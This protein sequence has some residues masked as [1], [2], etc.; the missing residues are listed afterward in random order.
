MPSKTCKL[1]IPYAHIHPHIIRDAGFWT[2]RWLHAGRSPS[3]LAR[4]TRRLWFPTGLSNLNSSDHRTLFHF[5]KQSILNEPWPTGHNGASGPW[6]LMASFLHDRA[7]VGICRWHGGLCLLRVVSGSI[8]G[9]NSNVNDRIMSMS[10]AASSE[11]P[12]TTSFHKSLRP[13]PLRTE[14]SPVSLNLL[15]MLFAKPLQFA[16]EERCF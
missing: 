15:M 13:C 12:K 4:R 16:V 11:G 10:D 1:P 5:S 3:S 14:I 2:E 8:P 6:S 7:L 9:P